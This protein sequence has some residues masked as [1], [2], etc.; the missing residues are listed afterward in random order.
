LRLLLLD[1][2]EARLFIFR[3][4]GAAEAEVAQGDVYS[5]LGIE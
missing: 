4:F 3:Q 1:L 2:G 5:S